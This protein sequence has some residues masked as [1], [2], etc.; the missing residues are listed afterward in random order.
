MSRYWLWQLLAVIFM[1]LAGYGA[2]RIYDLGKLHGAVELEALR[3]ENADLMRQATDLQKSKRE[4]R[5]RYI[6]LERSSQI[7][8]QANLEIRQGYGSL[9]EEL[10]SVR[11]ELE[12][13]RGIVSPG[14]VPPGLRIHRF[15]IS[16]LQEGGGLG[17]ELI[18]IQVKKNDR[19]VSG[20]ITMAIDGL[21]DGKPAKLGLADLTDPQAGQLKFKFR[22]FQKIR[23]Q[24]HLPPD[25]RPL[26]LELAVDPV[27]KNNKQEITRTLE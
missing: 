27:G 10:Q 21:Q 9:Q 23:G 11:E 3:R 22:Y 25:F 14:D 18:L 4:L 5:R 2:W 8:Q 19:P 16:P 6:M 26:L 12:F 17:Y 1:G 24:L 13:Y 7:D 15:D 20:T